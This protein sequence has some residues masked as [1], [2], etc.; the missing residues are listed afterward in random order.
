MEWRQQIDINPAVMMGKPCIK[1]TRIT[2]ELI[3]EKLA[4][5]ETSEQIIESYPHVT[6]ENIRSCLFYAANLTNSVWRKE[7]GKREKEV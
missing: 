5:G 3:V 6:Q 1:G 2:V 7:Y 4:Y